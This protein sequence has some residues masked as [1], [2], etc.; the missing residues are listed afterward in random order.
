MATIKT[1]DIC[2]F[3]VK[4]KFF[5]KGTCNKSHPCQFYPK[6]TNS[7]CIF[8]HVFVQRESTTTESIMT[9]PTKDPGFRLKTPNAPEK[10]NDFSGLR[11]DAPSFIPKF[12]VQSDDFYEFTDEIDDD[13]DA[14]LG[15]ESDDE[16]SHILYDGCHYL[17]RGEKFTSYDAADDAKLADIEEF[18]EISAMIMAS[19]N[20]LSLSC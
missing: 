1:S 19:M 7:G 15:D 9:T 2:P 14:E 11:A 18:A 6:C 8:D 17:Y 13:F 5:K 16:N 20:E 12:N 4:C 10:L 3:A